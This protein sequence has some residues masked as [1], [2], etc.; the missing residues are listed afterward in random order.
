ME[1]VKWLC[2]CLYYSKN[3]YSQAGF[4]MNTIR[5]LKDGRTHNYMQESMTFQI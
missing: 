2:S 4:L 5:I 1:K 3:N